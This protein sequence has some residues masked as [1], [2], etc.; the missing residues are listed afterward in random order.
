MT[1]AIPLDQQI[2]DALTS[3][4]AS[5]HVAEVLAATEKAFAELTRRAAAAD[6]ASLS[7]LANR[8]KAGALRAEAADLRFEASRLQ[9]SVAALTDRVASLQKAERKAIEDAE[10]NA[11]L[12]ERDALAAD[13]AAQY[14]GIVRTLT[15]LV[16]RIHESDKRCRAIGITESAENIGRRSVAPPSQHAGPLMTLSEVRLPIVGGAR[17]AWDRHVGLGGWTYSGLDEAVPVTSES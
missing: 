10:R 13:I 5:V 17:A 9:A 1:K 7:P 12:A 11:A 14:P 15:G 16:K 3:P 4:T 8:E 2:V 6:S